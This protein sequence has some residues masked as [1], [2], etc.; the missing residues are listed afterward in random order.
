MF[1]AIVI[2]A[3]AIAAYLVGSS[4]WLRLPVAM[5]ATAGSATGILLSY[6]AAYQWKRQATFIMGEQTASTMATQM[7]VNQAMIA[8]ASAIGVAI[9]AN[10]RSKQRDIP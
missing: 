8:V 3:S 6:A 7:F 9:W 2:L 4:R 5:G 10:R 1:S